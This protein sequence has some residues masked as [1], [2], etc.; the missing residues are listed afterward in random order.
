MLSKSPIIIC[1]F[2]QYHNTVIITHLKTETSI[3]QGTSQMNLD[4]RMSLFHKHH[5]V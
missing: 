5:F 2:Q 3:H 4:F 1:D